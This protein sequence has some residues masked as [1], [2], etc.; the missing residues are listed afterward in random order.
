MPQVSDGETVLMLNK[1]RT[2]LRTAERS[3][4]AAMPDKT[5]LLQALNRM[6]SFVYILMIREKKH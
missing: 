5:D 4:V 1:L 6:S 2:T 3:A